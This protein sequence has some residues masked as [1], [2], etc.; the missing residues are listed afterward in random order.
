MAN[1][2]LAH[3]LKL[4]GYYLKFQAYALKNIITKLEWALKQQARSKF[5]GPRHT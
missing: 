2:D 1:S 3:P 4:Y 5:R